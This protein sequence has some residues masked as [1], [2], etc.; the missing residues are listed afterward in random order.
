MSRVIYLGFDPMFERHEF[1]VEDGRQPDG[2]AAYRGTDGTTYFT[3][4]G[5]QV[6]DDAKWRIEARH[7]R[8]LFDALGQA[9]GV[10]GAPERANLR[11]D[12]EHERDRVDKMLDA[13]IALASPVP[14]L[15][16]M[17]V[18]P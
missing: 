6:H 18:G 7:V 15:T 11:A 10:A 14:L 3:Q 8:P 1:L 9:L 5:M 2:V 17:R 13:V 12:F 4:P 16:E